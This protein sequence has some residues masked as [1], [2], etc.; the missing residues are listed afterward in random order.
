MKGNRVRKIL[1]TIVLLA[2][3]IATAASLGWLPGGHEGAPKVQEPVATTSKQPEPIAVTVA[4]AVPRAVERRVRIVGTLHGFE[5]I[6][7][8]PLVD[9][10]VRKVLHDVGDVV[11]PGETLAL[12]LRLQLR[13]GPGAYDHAVAN[14][15]HTAQLGITLPEGMSTSLNSPGA[16]GVSSPL[17]RRPRDFRPPG[18]FDSVPASTSW[19]ITDVPARA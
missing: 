2:G 19:R 1:W 12:Q 11:Q 17:I 16:M 7:I 4:E 18:R 8:S 6:K 13:V 15:G 5:E 3:G 14:F 10:H 9:G